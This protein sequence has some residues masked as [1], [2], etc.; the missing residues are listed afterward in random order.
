MVQLIRLNPYFVFL[1][2]VNSKTGLSSSQEKA[3]N[4]SVELVGD[5]GCLS[6]V[7][8]LLNDL[9]DKGDEKE[10]QT[11]E[12]HVALVS[13]KNLIQLDPGNGY[14]NIQIQQGDMKSN[15]S[16]SC[17]IPNQ[18]F[19]KIGFQMVWFSKGLAIAMVPSI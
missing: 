3:D 1:K 14:P 18:D 12:L 19:L 5:H 15:H 8:E 13:K 11:Y 10:L 4:E 7:L 9:S 6:A 2:V 16:K 17:A